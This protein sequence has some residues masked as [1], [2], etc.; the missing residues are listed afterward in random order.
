[1]AQMILDLESLSGGGN[2]VS[3]EGFYDSS[4]NYQTETTSTSQTLRIET[5]LSSI[6]RFTFMANPTYSGTKAYKQ[7][8]AYDADA[9]PSVF[10]TSCD[11]STG[12]YGRGD[13]A[14]NTVVDYCFI[15]T[16]I[17]GGTVNMQATSRNNYAQCNNIRWLAE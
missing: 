1:M 15:I 3:G 10:H 7:V 4:D 2:A 17:S 14:L 6:K 8:V 16:S 13:V 5:G 9:K 12:S 11:H